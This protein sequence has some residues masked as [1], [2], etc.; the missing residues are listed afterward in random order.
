MFRKI[1]IIYSLTVGA[2]MIAMWSFLIFSG[3]VPELKTEPYSIAFHLAGEGFTAILLMAGGIGLIKNSK[4]SLHVH[5]ISLGMLIY[6]VIVSSGYYVDLGQIIIPVVFA[7]I[8]VLAVI[9]CIYAF[10][11]RKN[12]G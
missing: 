9:L 5:L 10:T 4:W 11:L 7:V 6:T 8:F 2:V 12:L 1:S 3:K